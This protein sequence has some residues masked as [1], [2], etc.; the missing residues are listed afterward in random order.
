MHLDLCSALPTSFKIY[1]FVACEHE[2]MNISPSCRAG[3]AS[4]VIFISSRLMWLP[5]LFD[6]IGKFIV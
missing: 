2:Y 3:Y 4:R 1:C 6:K 5:T